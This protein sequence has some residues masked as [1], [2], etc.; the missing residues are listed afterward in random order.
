MYVIHGSWIP[1]ITMSFKNS[2]AFYI[3]VE[4]D[5]IIDKPKKKSAVNHPYHLDAVT[6]IKFFKELGLTGILDIKLCSSNK[7]SKEGIHDRVCYFL[8]P[9]AKN[10]PVYSLDILKYHNQEIP[11]KCDWSCCSIHCVEVS[12]PLLF[13]KEIHFAQLYFPDDIKIGCDLDFWIQYANVFKE[14]ILK[15]QYIPALKC[16]QQKPKKKNARNKVD[17]AFYPQWQIVS[18]EYQENLKRYS[19]AMPIVCLTGT[20][21]KV[22]KPV[23]YDPE[24][25]LQ[26]F[27]EN[28]LDEIISS[29]Q[30]PRNIRKNVASTFI[31]E[32]ISHSDLSDGYGC[33]SDEI[34]KVWQQWYVW[35]KG[36]ALSQSEASFHFCF[37]L[38]SASS[39]KPDDW[40]IE[41]LM[42]SKKDPSFKVP[43]KNYWSASSK[44]HQHY[45]KYLGQ[46]IDKNLLIQLGHA[47]KIYSHLDRGLNTEYPIGVSIN[48][49]EAFD[50]LK[51]QAWVL[52]NAGYKVIVPVWWTPK[53]RRRGKIR[54]KSNTTSSKSSD[55]GKGYFSA[56]K[57]V[58]FQYEFSIGGE[59]VSP[60]EWQ[61]LVNA[62]Q[63]LVQF[64]GNWLE[65]EQD[66]MAAMLEFWRNNADNMEEASLM[67][68]IKRAATEEEDYEFVFDDTLS[69][70]MS[71]LYDKS[72]F[73]EKKKLKMFQGK[74]RP[75]QKRGYS[76][77]IYLEQLGLCPCLADDM[78]LGKTI[79]IIALLVYE[80]EHLKEKPLPTLLIAPT[81]VLS[82]WEKEIERFA[83]NLHVMIHHGGKRI[84]TEK[85]LIEK[86]K[87]HDVVITSFAL[88]RKDV[89][90]FNQIDWQR[91]VVDEAQN[92][93]NPKSAQ[94]RAILKFKGK[95]RIA[96]TGTPIENRLLDMWS[97]F[98]FL[99][100]GFLGTVSQFKNSFEIPI[101]KN[102][103][104]ARAKILKKLVEPFILRRLKTDKN[105][106]EDLPDKIEQKVYCNLTKEQASLY[107]AVVQEVE[108]TINDVDGIQRKG[109]I[110]S[111]LMKLKQICNHPAQYLQDESAFSIERS[112]KL[113]RLSEMAEEALANNESMLVFTQF[114][115][116][117]SALEKLFRS[118]CHYNTYFLHGGTSRK[119]RDKIINE[120]Q[121]PDTEPSVFILTVK[122][123]GVGITLTKAN[124]V[125]HFDRWWNPSVE[126]QATDR[127]YR[128]G[129]EKTVFAH[130]FVALGTLEERIDKMLEEKQRLSESIIGGSESWLSKLDNEAFRD[131]I[132]LSRTAIME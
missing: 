114:A 8:M 6:S 130:K 123:G 86:C 3:W 110:L 81:S 120:F 124:H 14:V 79:Q 78:G 119:L 24:M 127:A 49:L 122:A 91:V 76:W 19:Q 15:D 104:L 28:M 73:T 30:F 56:S 29:I 106:I 126:N 12:N 118:Q 61:A 107:Q 82:N 84:K 116:V 77:L 45:Q 112:H 71:Q 75:Y 43:L 57:L 95:S 39:K 85:D 48:M 40:H 115:E 2:G 32:C 54:V 89:K 13:F 132:K 117:G 47:S 83:S 65:L 1:E 5:E 42:E 97:I 60:E 102:N 87:K 111:T 129:Q 27:S 88:A 100:P 103:D 9:T 62:K 37:R 4:A 92:I 31:D 70:M 63:P 20:I 50:F 46:D 96:L 51:E 131:L 53:G 90:L 26:H 41:F 94:T 34:T 67:D 125:F 74:L 25:L 11:N 52:Q 16:Y 113:T 58:E 36:L 44:D 7:I 17:I 72:K 121:D 101:Q 35:Q 99:N 59:S 66:K 23:S 22:K 105:I 68:L 98:H 64:R 108:S 33:S 10:N 128:I 69:E 38:H 80:R 109:L 93:K 18:R 55:K 21:K